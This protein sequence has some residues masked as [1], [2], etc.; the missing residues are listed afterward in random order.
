MTYYPLYTVIYTD[1]TEYYKYSVRTD[2]AESA[3]NACY[4]ERMTDDSGNYIEGMA[5]VRILE[6]GVCVETF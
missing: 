4:F 6:D 3:S 5:F 1:G 2:S